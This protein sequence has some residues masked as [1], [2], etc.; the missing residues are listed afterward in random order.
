M[1]KE[2]VS[3]K[4]LEKALKIKLGSDEIKVNLNRMSIVLENDGSVTLDLDGKVN[5]PI[6]VLGKLLSREEKS[7]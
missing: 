7:K 4:V 1:L 6:G 3:E 2:I 5:A